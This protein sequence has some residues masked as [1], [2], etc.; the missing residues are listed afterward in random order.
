ML[1][2]KIAGLGYH[3]PEQRVSSADLEEAWSLPPGWIER[4]TGVRERRYATNETS[5]GM[6]AV[7]I[8]R[9]LEMAGLEVDEVDLIVGA[10]T[11]PQQAIPCTA[12]LVQRE[13][14]APEGRSTCFDINATCL[15]F[16]YT[17][18]SVS[19]LVAANVYRVAA[20]YSSEVTTHSLNPKEPESAVLFG[21]SA[22][23]AIITR[24][25]PDEISQLGHSQFATYSSGA[26]LTCMIGSGTLHH[27]NA[28]DSTPE[29][30]MFHMDG[31]A[32]FK[33]ATRL[34]GPFLTSY[35]EHCCWSQDEIDCVI[36]HQ[37]SRHGLAVLTSRLGFRSEQ[38]FSNLAERGNCIAASIPLGLAEAVEAQRIRRGDKVL[39]VGSGAGL[40]LGAVT[41]IF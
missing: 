28:P 22:A 25:N 38:I 3:L 4:V 26:D 30:S 1:P 37:A 18:Q 31:P 15:S 39:L 20:I 32:V 17:L 19:H 2:V 23:A 8:L 5:A 13:L 29:M 41:L 33:K 40:T 9:A 14:G 12:V 10:S 16:L 11:G 35:F 36:P 27:P 7:A 24:S 6:G 34:I 21:D